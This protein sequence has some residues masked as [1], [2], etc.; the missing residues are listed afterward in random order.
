MDMALQFQGTHLFIPCPHIIY[1]QLITIIKSIV[2][3]KGLGCI[4]RILNFKFP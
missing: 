1:L 3:G 4:D 2:P